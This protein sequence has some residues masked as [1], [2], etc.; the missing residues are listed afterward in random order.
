MFG[1]ETTIRVVV[2]V[3]VVVVGFHRFFPCVFYFFPLCCVCFS[4]SPPLSPRAREHPLVAQTSSFINHMFNIAVS[5]KHTCLTLYIL[6]GRAGYRWGNSGRKGPF[7]DR[8]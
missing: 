3:V 6:F 7:R 5:K 4:P 2:V 8:A 1:C